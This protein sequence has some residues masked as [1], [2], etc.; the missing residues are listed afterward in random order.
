MIPPQYQQE[1]PNTS[2]L[3]NVGIIFFIMSFI[4]MA[5]GICSIWILGLGIIPMLLSIPLFIVGIVLMIVG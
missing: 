3:R 5:F 2:S 4:F 1:P